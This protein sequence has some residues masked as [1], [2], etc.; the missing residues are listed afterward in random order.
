MS[1]N[2]FGIIFSNMHDESVQELTAKRT[3][4]SIPFGGRYRL[5]DFVLSNMYNSGITKVGVITKS[6]Y[7]SLMDHIG[8]GKEWDL[9]RKREGLF[10]LPPF[11][12]A[13]SGVYKGRLEALIG[14][15]EFINH[16]TGDYIIMS[17]CDTICNLNYSIALEQHIKDRADVTV[18]CKRC[19]AD[20]L[21][22]RETV[23]YVPDESG[24]VKEI[25]ISPKQGTECDIGLNMWIVNR[26]FLENALAE[27]QSHSLHS[28]ERDILQKNCANYRIFSWNFDGYAG[29]INTMH[30]YFRTNM[31]LLNSTVRSELFFKYGH[32]YTKVRDEV[33]AKYGDSAKV[34]NSLIADGCVIEGEVENSIL[35]R[36]VSV[37][38][39]AKISNSIIM[40]GTKIDSNV[41]LN[42]VII[43]KDVFIK[44]NRI[45]MSFD[46]YPLYIAKGS[47]V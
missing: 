3:M 34:S 23:S 12:S 17:D 5:I 41:K 44:D 24:R 2:A 31:D 30:Q 1:I 28:W 14:I 21:G 7:Q 47:I 16:S 38:R 4:A 18:I 20:N 35:F 45:L 27:A 6:N 43:D 11:G 19:H 26:R 22:A 40:Q 37:G 33:P 13:M 29:R 15:S 36:G 32:I 39:G 25:V 8:S 9:S 42:Y 10:I 46:S